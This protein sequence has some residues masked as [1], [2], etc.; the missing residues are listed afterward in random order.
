MVLRITF[1]GFFTRV[2]LVFLSAEP[3]PKILLPFINIPSAYF[4]Q[5]DVR[6]NDFNL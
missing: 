2:K 3:I 5:I 6:V 1:Y 4:L